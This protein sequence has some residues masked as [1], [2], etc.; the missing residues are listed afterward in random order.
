M[1]SC[2]ENWLKFHRLLVCLQTGAPAPFSLE[3]QSRGKR[4]FLHTWLPKQLSVFQYLFFLPELI[5]YKGFGGGGTKRKTLR[6]TK[7]KDSSLTAKSIICIMWVMRWWTT[8]SR[9]CLLRLRLSRTLFSCLTVGCPCAIFL[10]LR[11]L[12]FAPFRLVDLLNT[13]WHWKA[14]ASIL[15]Q[16]TVHNMLSM[17]KVCQKASGMA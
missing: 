1:A 10:I 8:V 17:L 9:F 2:D 11:G 4:P 7:E 14:E 15:S 16:L 12:A 6:G 3:E 13:V 5:F